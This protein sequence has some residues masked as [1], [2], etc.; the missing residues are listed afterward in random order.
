[1]ATGVARDYI[2][3]RQR[4]NGLPGEVV[5]VAGF[6]DDLRDSRFATAM[7]RAS[8]QLEQRYP[9]KDFTMSETSPKI[10]DNI[11]VNGAEVR[12]YDASEFLQ[13]W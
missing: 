12:M 10:L 9:L 5:Y 13:K 8:V 11:N 3:V 6:R 2:V 7:Q 1:M 4:Q